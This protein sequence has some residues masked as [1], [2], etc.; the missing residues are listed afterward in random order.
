[1]RKFVLCAI[2]A[3]ICPACVKEPMMSVRAFDNFENQF[4][5]AWKA[6]SE[7]ETLSM[8]RISEARDD[9]KVLEKRVKILR[10][11]IGEL[12]PKVFKMDVEIWQAV[13]ILGKVLE[14]QGTKIDWN[15]EAKLLEKEMLKEL[16]KRKLQKK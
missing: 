8:T 4:K 6:H 13:A 11:I 10:G 2:F 12:Y 3:F 16:E 14:R 1:M 9:I 15:K 7:A 5:Q